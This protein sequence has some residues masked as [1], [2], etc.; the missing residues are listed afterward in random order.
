MDS[1]DSG[2]RSEYSKSNSSFVILNLLH[3]PLR[4]S[5]YL[6]HWLHAVLGRSSAIHLFAFSK[7]NPL[8]LKSC[9]NRHLP[10]APSLIT[11]SVLYVKAAMYL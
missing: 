3:N 1:M 5:A 10:Q 6:K 2:G 7:A 8:Y 4:L 11:A 9:Q